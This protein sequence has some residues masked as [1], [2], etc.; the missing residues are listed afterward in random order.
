MD[1]HY[2]RPCPFCGGSAKVIGG[3]FI[4][5]PQ[6]DKIGEYIGMGI[7]PDCDIA[8]A[9]VECEKCHACGPEFEN[10]VDDKD[11]IERAV[12]AWNRRT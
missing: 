2:L 11:L 6:F 12:E 4:P 8:P 1:E 10:S 9:G 3:N 7:T 5:E